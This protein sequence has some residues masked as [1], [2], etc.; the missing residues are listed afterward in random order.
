M[1]RIKSFVLGIFLLTFITVL[2][3]AP[4]SAAISQEE[5]ERQ[6]AATFLGLPVWYKYLSP[7]Y[8]SNNTPDT[9]DDTCELDVNFTEPATY[10]AILLAIFEI[11]MRI[12]AIVAVVFVIIGGL[13]F[14]TSDGQPDKAKQARWTILNALIGLAITLVAVAIVNLIGNTLT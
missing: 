13:T 8:D 7:S 4:A 10:S 11:I 2:I 6:T 5:C 14:V 9:A 1:S 12:A 3:P